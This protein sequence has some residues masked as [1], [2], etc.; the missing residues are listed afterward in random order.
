MNL[1]LLLI[2]AVGKGQINLFSHLHDR[3]RAKKKFL[4]NQF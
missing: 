4:G 3:K 1:A 2:A